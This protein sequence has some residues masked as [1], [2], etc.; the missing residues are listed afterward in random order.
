MVYLT[1]LQGGSFLLNYIIY[2][3]NKLR[4]LQLKY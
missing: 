1:D 2:N 3:W 4:Y